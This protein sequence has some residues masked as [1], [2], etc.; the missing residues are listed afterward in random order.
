MFFV[1]IGGGTFA[2]L[3]LSR[4]LDP[5]LPEAPNP[6]NYKTTSENDD[7]VDLEKGDGVDLPLRPRAPRL[8]R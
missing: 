8:R 2:W 1:A 4:V 5:T 7:I 3:A 6:S